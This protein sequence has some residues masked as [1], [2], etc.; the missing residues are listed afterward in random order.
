MKLNDGRPNASTFK[1]GNMAR[2]STLTTSMQ[3]STGGLASRTKQ[4]KEMKFWK[5]KHKTIFIYKRQNH[6]YRET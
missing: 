4:E 3:Y 5:A 1:T 2:M 6:L